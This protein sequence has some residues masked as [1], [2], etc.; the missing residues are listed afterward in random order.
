ML[1]WQPLAAYYPYQGYDIDI[2]ST[3]QI[4][5]NK[6]V[7]WARDK[8]TSP[9][10]PHTHVATYAAMSYVFSVERDPEVTLLR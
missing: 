9:G 5:P 4:E 10:C 7:D 1:H 2:G 6:R 8:T 3:Y